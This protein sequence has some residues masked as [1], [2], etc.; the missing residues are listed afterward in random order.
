MQ[1][2]SPTTFGWTGFLDDVSLVLKSSP[3]LSFLHCL[4]ILRNKRRMWRRTGVDK[5]F[6]ALPKHSS[7]IHL[8]SADSL[9]ISLGFPSWIAT[10][11]KWWR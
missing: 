2:T 4:L 9:S 3:P 11:I 6:S 7:N 8:L 5:N 1:T 10:D